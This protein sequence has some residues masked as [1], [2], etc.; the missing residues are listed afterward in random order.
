MND[1]II[2]SI[3]DS[4]DENTL[5]KLSV[6][7]L[8]R[9]NAKN[10]VY[11]DR[12]LKR[13][14][15]DLELTVRST[16]CLKN[17]GIFYIGELVQCTETDL[18]QM[19]YLGKKSLN[20]IKTILN[21]R[22]LFLNMTIKEWSINNLPYIKEN[23]IWMSLFKLDEDSKRWTCKGRLLKRLKDKQKESKNTDVL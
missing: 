2:S 6:M 8:E 3:L 23:D 22:K 10:V 15:D 4:L 16:N 7:I 5:Q 11:H 21:A 12:I 17:D 14:I 20:E 19:P 13:P 18:L 9:I 1:L